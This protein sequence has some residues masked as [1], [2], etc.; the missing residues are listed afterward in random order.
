MII[1]IIISITI[2][3]IVVNII[4]SSSIVFFDSFLFF[5]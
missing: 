3:F 4:L 2:S 1:M 5:Y